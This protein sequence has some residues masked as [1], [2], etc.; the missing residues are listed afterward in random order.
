MNLTRGLAI[1]IMV[2]GLASRQS[3]CYTGSGQFQSDAALENDLFTE[4]RRQL[5]KASKRR[6]K[7]Q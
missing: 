5:K 2:L 1:V 7:K 4:L 3:L 6:E